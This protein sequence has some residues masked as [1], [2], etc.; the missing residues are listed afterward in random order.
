MGLRQPS[1]LN[2]RQVALIS[3]ALKHGDAEYTAVSH[4]RSHRVTEQSARTDL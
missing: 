2:H 4:S 3:H 1:T